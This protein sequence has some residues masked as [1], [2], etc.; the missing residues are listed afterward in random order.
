MRETCIFRVDGAIIRTA[1]NFVGGLFKRRVS[2]VPFVRSEVSH[3]FRVSHFVSTHFHF[4]LAHFS[5]SCF[6]SQATVYLNLLSCRGKPLPRSDFRH[7]VTG[8][9][10]AVTHIYVDR[11]RK[12][13]GI[14]SC[15]VNHILP[16]SC[17][18]H[19]YYITG[20]L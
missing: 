11:H 7:H 5:S 17:W 8:S 9:G 15:V 20:V 12:F 3:A 4:A 6:S 16:S 2:T 19:D 18:V 1:T 14:P 13:R 10:V